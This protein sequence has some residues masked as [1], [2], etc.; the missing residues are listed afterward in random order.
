[1]VSLTFLDKPETFKSDELFKR[2]TT[3]FKLKR[4][5]LQNN[6]VFGGTLKDRRRALLTTFS[7]YIKWLE[8]VSFQESIFQMPCELLLCWAF[9]MKIWHMQAAFGEGPHSRQGNLYCT[10]YGSCRKGSK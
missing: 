5:K 7:P 2:L 4:L 6:T 3:H 9:L 10:K 8:L 1:M